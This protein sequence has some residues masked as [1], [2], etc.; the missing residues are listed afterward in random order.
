MSWRVFSFA[1]ISPPA[2]ALVV[3]LLVLA[4]V[5]PDMP[6]TRR[7]WIRRAAICGILTG[8][9]V[10]LVVVAMVVYFLHVLSHFD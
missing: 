4:G 9:S 1:V 2:I 8:V 3:S 10:G 7:K 5:S 6:E